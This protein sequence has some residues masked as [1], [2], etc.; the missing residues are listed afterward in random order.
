M[1]LL[2]IFRLLKLFAR[3]FAQPY[4]QDYLKNVMMLAIV[5]IFQL[6]YYELY[7]SS[8]EGIIR[9]DCLGEQL[10]IQVF[11]VSILLLL[12][13]IQNFLDHSL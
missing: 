13:N 4:L 3:N 10:L 8:V 6:L 1:L 9:L 12:N 5:I 7:P 2:E 11:P